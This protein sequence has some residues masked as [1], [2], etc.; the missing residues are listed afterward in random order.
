[1][2]APNTHEWTEVDVLRQIGTV[3]KSIKATLVTMLL[4]QAA[5]IALAV[6]ISTGFIE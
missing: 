5:G 3:L 1:M 6:A 2:T 4:L